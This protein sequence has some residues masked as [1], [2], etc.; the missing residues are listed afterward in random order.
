VTL[1]KHLSIVRSLFTSF[2]YSFDH[3]SPQNNNFSERDL[4]GWY[5]SQNRL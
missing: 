5:V 1:A 2:R 4:A 3:N